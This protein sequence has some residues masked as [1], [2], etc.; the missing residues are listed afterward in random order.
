[1]KFNPR[2]SKSLLVS[3]LRS[4]LPPHPLLYVDGDQ[5]Q[6]ERHMKVLGVVLD[7]K[8]TYEEHSLHVASRVRQKTSIP[9]LAWL[10]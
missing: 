5:K 3:R 9:L 8:L 2:K 1:M 4:E 10:A 7:S 6:E